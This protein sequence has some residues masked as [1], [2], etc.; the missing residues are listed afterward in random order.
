MDANAK[1]IMVVVVVCLF[2]TCILIA[3][4]LFW[5]RIQAMK[6]EG[7]HAT[8][9]FPAAIRKTASRSGF[10]GV[11]EK[12]DSR[13][14]EIWGKKIEAY[15]DI[16]VAGM[17]GMPP[18][19]CPGY[20]AE[21]PGGKQFVIVSSSQVKRETKTDRFPVRHNGWKKIADLLGSDESSFSSTARSYE[22][23]AIFSPSPVGVKIRSFV[24]GLTGYAWVADFQYVE[25]IALAVPAMIRGKNTLSQTMGVRIIRSR[26]GSYLLLLSF[27]A[28]SF[29]STTLSFLPFAADG[30][31]ALR[32]IARRMLA[33]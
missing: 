13:V 14:E 25:K 16:P 7:G 11:S 22:S 12:D 19:S 15:G 21:Y 23:R 4:I 32:E 9:D 5:R 10:G 6:K 3:A 2:D 18:S 24:L 26:D 30:R 1:L 29:G 17:F 33:F 27:R 8:A 31:A 20:F 28:A